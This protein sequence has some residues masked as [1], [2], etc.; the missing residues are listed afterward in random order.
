VI[1]FRTPEWRLGG[2]VMGERTI[3]AEG[4]VVFEDVLNNRKAVILFST[5]K[6]TGFFTTV[7]TGQKDEY[8]GLIY[9]STPLAS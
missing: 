7:E 8:N 3:E 4:N 2:T 6:K 1:R 5:Y 9:E